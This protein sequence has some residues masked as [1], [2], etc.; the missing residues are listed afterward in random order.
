MS[1]AFGI[2]QTERN[3]PPTA[4]PDRVTAKPTHTPTPT[5]TS[6]P[7]CASVVASTNAWIGS[8]GLDTTFGMGG[9]AVTDASGPASGNETVEKVLV[10]ADG[11]VVT[12]GKAYNP[13]NLTGQDM[14]V[15]RYNSNGTPDTGF[16]SPDPAHPGQRLG[17]VFVDFSGGLD[18]GE[19]G[20]IDPAGRILIAGFPN[21]KIARL[22]TNGD[23]DPSF[24]VGGK[25]ETVIPYFSPNDI[26]LQSNGQIV[27]GGGETTFMVARFN[28]NGS[29]DTSFG[30]GGTVSVNISGERRGTAS[31]HSVSIQTISGEERIVLAG[32]SAAT[33]ANATFAVM[34]FRPNGQVDGSFGTNG[35]VLTSFY[36]LGAEIFEHKT[37]ASNRLVA[38]GRV[39]TACGSDNGYAR[40]TENGALDTTFSGDGLL[41][42]SI[43]SGGG[44]A[45]SVAIQPDGKIVIAGHASS[46][47]GNITDF[48]VVRLL[49]DGTPDASFGPGT[50]LGSGIVTTDT[51]GTSG[52]FG[53]SIAIAPDGNIVVGGANGGTS[54]VT[55]YLP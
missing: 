44:Y 53:R 15:I 20:V 36:G 37:D 40:Y 54:V 6:T 19:S 34:R 28:S 48:T 39:F 29:L 23:L 18:R 43:F 8:G 2:A 27:L 17:Y 55:R 45:N 33:A 9:I 51:H 42:Q 35:V 1:A 25:I 10:Q 16:G 22:D 30:N 5:P 13:G 24:G 47:V 46:L 31:G 38:V 3:L 21:A 32:S 4:E 52:S 11:K 49:S 50:P 41:T 26:A 7:G 14:L 12:V